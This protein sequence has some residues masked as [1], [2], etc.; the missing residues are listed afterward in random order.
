LPAAITF[1]IGCP[2][3]IASIEARGIFAIGVPSTIA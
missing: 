3:T 1:L 2:A